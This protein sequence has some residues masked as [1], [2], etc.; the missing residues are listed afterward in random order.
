MALV[1]LRLAT[2]RVTA[3][4]ALE[5]GFLAQL[6]G[7]ESFEGGVDALAALA[8]HLNLVAEALHRGDL[9]RRALAV[10]RLEHQVVFTA[11]VA[12]VRDPL[13]IG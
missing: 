5:I 7:E 11:P 6:Y 3:E 1:L 9:P 4:E 12:E 8:L 10:L 2:V 13:A